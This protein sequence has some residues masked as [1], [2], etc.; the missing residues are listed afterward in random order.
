[1]KKLLENWK[2]FIKENDVDLVGARRAAHSYLKGDNNA[3]Y[4]WRSNDPG[5]SYGYDQDPTGTSVFELENR[6]NQLHSVFEDLFAAAE[7]I[8]GVE[9]EWRT[10]S[11]SERKSDYELGMVLSDKIMSNFPKLVEWVVDLRK[12][13]LDGHHDKLN[14]INEKT[15]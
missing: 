4:D 10:K 7:D 8:G 1:M 15:T 12:Y 9:E 13:V 6:H 2:R 5:S 11:K 14:Q 3:L